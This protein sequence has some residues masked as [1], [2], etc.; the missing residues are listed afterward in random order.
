[1]TLNPSTSTIT[2]TSASTKAFNG[3]GLTYYN[4]NQGGTG[5]LS[6]GGSNTFNDITNT[7]QP[8]T[9]SFTELTTQ[10][11]SNFSLSGTVGNLI[12]IQSAF[13]PLQFTLSKSSGTINAQYLSIKYSNATGGAVWN[14]RESTDAG[15]NTGWNIFAGQANMFSMFP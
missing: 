8:A 10:T 4:L 6:I 12:T 14:A 5:S 1:M 9:L 2:M 7:V 15:G 13:T 3:G 11:V